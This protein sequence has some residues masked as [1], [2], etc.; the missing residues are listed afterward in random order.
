MEALEMT[1]NLTIDFKEIE[2]GLFNFELK[3]GKQSFKTRF[4]DVYN[5]IPNLK[6]WLE[7]IAIGTQQ[8]SFVYDT[9]GQEIRLDFNNEVWNKAEFR[10]FD[11]Y[12]DPETF[13]YLKAIIDRKQ[14]VKVFYKGLLNYVQRGGF[15]NTPWEKIY[16]QDF[17]FFR[18]QI[19]E[20]T[21]T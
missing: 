1:E 13:C 18:S 7:A 19:I 20:E 6:H 10:A 17:S 12:V 21:I 8:T 16:D 11:I 3:I 14:L 2:H 15:K 5:P 9:E 4:S